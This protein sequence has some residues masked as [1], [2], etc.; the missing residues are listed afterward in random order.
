M[1]GVL[2]CVREERGPAVLQVVAVF[3]A[4]VLE[5]RPQ[6]L[7]WYWL[8]VDPGFLDHSLCCCPEAELSLEPPGSDHGTH[9]FA[10]FFECWSQK[11][12]DELCERSECFLRAGF[13]EIFGSH[14]LRLFYQRVRH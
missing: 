9:A 7:G 4:G 11:L 14:T 1:Y 12:R 8:C 5:D 6:D 10:D 13:D 3:K 2:C